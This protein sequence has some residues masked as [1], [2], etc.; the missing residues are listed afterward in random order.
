MKSR[1]AN[2]TFRWWFTGRCYSREMAFLNRRRMLGALAA[3]PIACS[4]PQPREQRS[5]MPHY[6]SLLAIGERIRR[7]EISPVEV[8]E[9]QLKRI[10]SLDSRLSAF[11]L[12]LADRARLQANQAE[13][14]IRS[15]VYRG[16]LHGVPIGLKDLLYIKGITTKGG[17]KVLSGFVPQYHAT[18]T[19][20]LESAGAVILG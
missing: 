13:A 7:K 4:P 5:S 20:K 3:T 11:Q 18:V 14:E 17:L 1:L 8:T 6:L 15:G 10:E 19:A 16:P 12:V 9:G 2:L